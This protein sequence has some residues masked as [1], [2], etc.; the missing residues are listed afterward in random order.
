MNGG[1]YKVK[2]QYHV[3]FGAGPLGLAVMDELVKNNQ[4]IILVNRSGIAPISDNVKVVKCDALNKQDVINVCQN[5]STVY[6]CL[7]LPYNEWKEKCPIVMENIIEGASMANAKIV[8]GDNLY[9][10]GPQ[11]QPLHENLKYNPVGEKTK[12]RAE[13]A[14]MLMN[15]H[16]AGKVIA[17]IGRGS[18]F[19]GPR[20][21][22]AVLGER[23]FKKL[24][25]SKKVELV[26]DPKTRHSH[27]FIEDFAKGLVKLGNESKAD[28]EVWHLPH[29]DAKTNFEL[30]NIIA[31][32]LGV[33]PNFRIANNF[34]VNVGAVFIP[35]MKEFKELMYQHTMDFIVDSTKYERTFGKSSTSFK[36]GIEKTISWYK[37]NN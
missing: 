36:D 11:N 2:K 30:V 18:D 29:E 24:I 25:D 3:I 37:D 34:I 8:Y 4:S 15:A 19:Y 33:E 12:V 9:A 35:L 28:G 6:H 20:V 16:K 1:I 14:T 5:A 31:N 10:Y 7:G 17:T 23:V 26:G 27:I 13:V 22:N 21:K 32:T